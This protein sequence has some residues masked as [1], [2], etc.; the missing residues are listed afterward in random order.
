MSVRVQAAV[1]IALFGGIFVWSAASQPGTV[2]DGRA[3]LDRGGNGTCSNDVL[4]VG[5]SCNDRLDSSGADPNSAP[6]RCHGG[7]EQDSVCVGSE[8]PDSF[9][10]EIGWECDGHLQVWLNEY[11]NW[12]DVMLPCTVM[13]NCSFF[14]P[15]DCHI[16]G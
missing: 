14:I 4:N 2:H 13:Y 3:A 5:N 1:L 7:T 15:G 11:N 10:W 8:L 12:I 16:Q 9:C 6:I